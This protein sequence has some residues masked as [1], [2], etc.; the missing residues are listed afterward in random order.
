M[1]LPQPNPAMLK[2]SKTLSRLIQQRILQQGKISFA[3][4]M[5][6]ALYYPGLGYYSA[7]AVKLG[8]SGDFITAP[9]ISPLFSYVLANQVSGILSELTNGNV[10]EF[11]AGTGC[12][13]AIILQQLANY[14]QLPQH[15]YILD[16]SA[17]L[18]ERQYQT[19]A[20]MCPELLDRI[21]WLSDLP[22]HFC[23]VVLANEVLD[24][25]P[26]NVF[27]WQHQKLFE[28]FVT[29]EKD[30]F[31][32]IDAPSETPALQAILE[33]YLPS[34]SSPYISEVNLYLEAWL[35]R[36]NQSV[37]QGVVL[38]IDYGF[39]AHEYY[40]PQRQMG[41]LMCHYQHQAH[42]NPFL[43]PGLQDIT[44]HVDFT[45]VAKAAIAAEFDIVGYTNQASFLMANDILSFVP[46]EDIAT[47]YQHGQDVKRLIHPSEMGEL[48]KVMALGKP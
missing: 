16:V 32:W 21:V 42:P 46:N 33:E 36:L 2:I 39:P 8:N 13:A 11:G 25:M 7:G 30:T 20:T 27:L 37:Q 15:Y 14:G 18:R 12:M 19:L 23:G 10:L 1:T 47:Q 9:E 35:Q 26:V 6:M 38:L 29:Y 41:T 45:A 3:E 24:A 34:L 4:F 40:H 5:Q 31:C 44:A 43:W 28:R 22:A 48:F 17:D